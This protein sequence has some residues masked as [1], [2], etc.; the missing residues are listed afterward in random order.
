METMNVDKKTPLRK[1]TNM[2]APAKIKIKF[3][4]Y[5]GANVSATTIIQ[6]LL[7]FGWT[8]NNMSHLPIANK[9]NQ[10]EPVEVTLTWQDTNI[11][12]KLLIYPDRTLSLDLCINQKMI[13]DPNGID[14]PDVN[15]YFTRLLPAFV[16]KDLW[17]A[18]FSF[19]QDFP[20]TKGH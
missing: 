8:L 11:G 15:W 7:D 20:I 12:G 13:L 16:H 17:L 9:E 19:D 1:V 18:Y 14:V 10:N 3:S 4:K 6:L 2:Q 5:Q